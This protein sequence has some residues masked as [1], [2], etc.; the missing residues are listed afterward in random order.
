ML[1]T[2]SIA[3]FTLS[4]LVACSLVVSRAQATVLTFDGSFWDNGRLV[5]D[6]YGRFVTGNTGS[7]IYGPECDITPN[8]AV[9]Y[10]GTM[11]WQDTGY[12]DLQNFIHAE[13]PA[14]ATQRFM[15]IVLA[16]LSGGTVA[17]HS[18]DLASELG[19]TLRID[20]IRV[21]ADGV[22][23]LDSIEPLIPG[24]AANPSHLR[25]AFDPPVIGTVVMIE[26]NLTRLI[27]KSDRIG[28]DNIKF[29]Q[30]GIPTP[31]ASVLFGAALG[32]FAFR[33]RR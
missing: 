1:R 12:G 7:F 16:N 9:D 24:D 32:L 33:R 13:H 18:F 8:V 3:L 28:I 22:R 11:R 17:L 14:N 25:I 5:P 20:W 30:P 2:N 4:T 23:V 10:V 19:E 15:T 21:F 27:G 31:G 6:S 29:S 26:L